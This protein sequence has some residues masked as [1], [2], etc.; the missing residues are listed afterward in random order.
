MDSTTAISTNTN[1]VMDTDS[2]NASQNMCIVI[3]R[4]V[5][6]RIMI[7][8]YRFR[9]FAIDGSVFLLP[10]TLAEMS[11]ASFGVSRS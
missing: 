10:H 6:G 9:F 2:R 3:Y 7:R 1:N 11:W 5:V 4:L 8:P